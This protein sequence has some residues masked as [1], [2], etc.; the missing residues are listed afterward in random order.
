MRSSGQLES[1]AENFDQLLLAGLIGGLRSQIDHLSAVERRLLEA[2]ATLG[3]Q[4][5]SESVATVLHGESANEVDQRLAE[6]ADRRL[7]VTAL[8][9]PSSGAAAA[10]GYRFRHPVSA[11]LLLS[12]ASAWTRSRL[13]RFKQPI[14]G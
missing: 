4:F 10:H 13:A 1:G 11:D 5:T 12:S 9:G 8:P 2:A 6:Y 14:A 7:F 3:V